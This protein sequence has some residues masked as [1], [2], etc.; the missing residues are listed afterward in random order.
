MVLRNSADQYRPNLIRRELNKAFVG[1]HSQSEVASGQSPPAA[2]ATGNWGCGAFGGDPYLKCLIQLMAAAESGRDLC[3]FTF[4]DVDLRDRF[5]DLVSFLAGVRRRPATVGDLFG[6]VCSYRR[7]RTEASNVFDHVID[8]LS[9]DTDTDDEGRAGDEKGETDN[10]DEHVAG[11]QGEDAGEEGEREEEAVTV[12]VAG[13]GASLSLKLTRR[14]EEEKE[15]QR[16]TKT[17]PKASPKSRMSA[18]DKMEVEATAA[19]ASVKE[20][21]SSSPR[22][23]PKAS[24]KSEKRNSKSKEGGGGQSQITDFFCKK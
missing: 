10:D 22:P 24:P 15:A 6:A 23:S 1:F 12:R 20:K 21:T 2:V 17:T 9:Y 13:E 3:Y 14:A 16:E 18:L 19:A 11:G 4:G 5:S 8:T 7:V